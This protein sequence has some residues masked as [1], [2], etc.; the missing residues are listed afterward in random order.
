MLDDP[1]ARGTSDRDC[2][3]SVLLIDRPHL[4]VSESGTRLS[5]T[6]RIDWQTPFAI[7][8]QTAELPLTDRADPFVP[9]GL[10][11][12]MRTGCDLHIDGFV[13][14]RQLRACATIQDIFTTWYPDR[15][16]RV[17]VSAATTALPAPASTKAGA[18]AFFPMGA[19]SFYT[20]LTCAYVLSHLLFVHGFDVRRADVAVAQYDIDL[21]FRNPH[22]WPVRI[23]A[24]L[25]GDGL[26]IRL[27]GREK[28][29]ASVRIETRMLGMTAPARRDFACAPSAC[30]D[31]T[32]KTIVANCCPKTAIR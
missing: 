26:E 11:A 20:A 10:I 3:Q 13:S 7:W 1:N 6:A 18:G 15:M 30:F 5:A 32:G 4:V 17:R 27:F 2:T 8:F 31:A 29:A 22:P 25:D 12:A 28:P 9:L 24:R 16:R 23:A 19:D 14:P 21:R